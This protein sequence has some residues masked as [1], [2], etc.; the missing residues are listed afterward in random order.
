MNTEVLKKPAFWIAIAVACSGV[1]LSQ[2]LVMEG[3]MPAQIIGWV[4]TVM[5]S[6]FGGKT[7][8]ELPAPTEPP[9]A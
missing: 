7:T 6:F 9:A 8:A 4:M 5:G 2:G 3:S 1:A